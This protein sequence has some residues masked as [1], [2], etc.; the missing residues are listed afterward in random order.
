[1]AYYTGPNEVELVPVR[2]TVAVQPGVLADDE[3]QHL[4]RQ[5][6]QTILS[7][8]PELRPAIVAAYQQATPPARRL[9]ED[10]A[11]GQDQEFLRSARPETWTR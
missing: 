2:L 11:A 8:K 7:H 10:A 9:I 1:M 6:I 4:V 5:E 3:I